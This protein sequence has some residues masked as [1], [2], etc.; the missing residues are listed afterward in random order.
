MWKKENRSLKGKMPLRDKCCQTDHHHHGCC[1]PVHTL[2]PGDPPLL[3]QPLQTSKSGIQQIIECFR[4]GTKQLKHILLKDVDTIFECKLCRSLFRGLPNLITHKKFYCTP[5]LLLDDNSPDVNDKQGQAISDLLEAM[6][7]RVDKQDYIIRLEPIETNKNAVFQYVSKA[8]SSAE[9]TEVNVTHAQ[10][11]VDI[12]ETATEPPNT[13]PAPSD[14]ETLDVFPLP[15]LTP[16]ANKAILI[17]GNSVPPSKPVLKC[18]NNSDSGHQLICSLCK[19]EFHSRRSIRRHIRKVHKKKMEELKKFIEMK[20]RPR[21]T[22]GRGRNKNILVTL[23]KSCTVCFKSF[24]TKANVRRHFDEVHRGLR[25]D[26]ITP[27]IATR[28]G[29]PLSLEKSS[30]KKSFKIRKQKSSSKTEYNLTTCKCLLCKRK[31]SSQLMLK[32][33]MLIVH[34]ITLSTKNAEKETKINNV[35]NTEAKVK[36]DSIESAELV[37]SLIISP[38]NDAKVTNSLNERKNEEGTEKKN[39]PS[40]ERKNI[41][42]T[43]KKNVPSFEKK[44]TTLVVK[45]PFTLA[46]GKSAPS[47][48]RKK[49]SAVERKNESFSKRKRAPSTEEKN[50]LPAK[51]KRAASAKRKG[52]KRRSAP[53]VEKRNVLPAKRKSESSAERKCAPPAKRKVAP[54]EKKS[55]L[56]AKRKSVL[57]AK[58]KSA[59]SAERKN[60]LPAERKNASS[61]EKISAPSGERKNASSAGRKNAS[62]AEKI[63]APSAE[64]KNVS[65]AGRENASSAEKVSAPS[66]ERKNASSAGREN[67]SSAEKINPPSAERENSSS[68]GRENASSAEKISPPSAERENSSSAGRKNSLSAGRKNSLSVGRRNASSAERKNAPSAGRKNAQSAEKKRTVSA[69][70][71]NA[72]S[73]VRKSMASAKEKNTPSV[74]R[75]NVS[76]ARKKCTASAERKRT[77]SAKK[78]ST[79]SAEKKSAASAEKKSAASTEKKSVASAEKKRAASAKKKCAASAKKK[80]A[81]SAKKKCAASSKKKCAASAK[82]KCAASAKKKCAASSRKKGTVSAE[83]KSA[84]CVEKKRAT[85]T[86]R[87]NVKQNSENVKRSGQNLVACPK[88]PRKPRLTPGFDFKK[89]YCKLCKRQFS[90]KQNLAKHIELHT[91]G[92]NIYVK[93][94]RCPLCTYETRRKRDVIRHITVVH[95]KSPNY[96]GKVTASLEVRAVKKSVDYVLNKVVKRGPHRGESKQNG[97]KQDITS[98]SPSKKYEGSDVGIEV[99]VTKNFSLHTCDICGKAFAKKTFLECHKKTHKINASHLIE[100]DNKTK[101]R[102]T[103]SKVLI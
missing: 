48:E 92:N 98:N 50:V 41:L 7:P 57:S 79:A 93:F 10:G 94:Y 61:A 58:R 43:E 23:G 2:E 101:G 95:K 69:E 40:V 102:S 31:Y 78:K 46:D 42:P 51:K 30:A 52:E 49:S 3:Q 53:T 25:R 55:S 45:K 71:K 72:S 63:S 32:R 86:K 87:N 33:H 47:T 77:A 76:S 21:Q 99:K 67:A 54:S 89:L 64:R 85:P 5:S 16:S 26:S 74:E 70:S 9:N 39:T 44:S 96:L 84:A 11:S 59:P 6:Y 65:S 103:R 68:A 22:F 36:T 75:K 81:A 24:A 28:P 18:K 88:K 38:H 37:P 8:D 4:S 80:C 12:S 83:K 14:S 20:K 19:K 73:A 97:L 100:E 35:R 56:S 13:I 91:D 90:S 29:Q 27:D 66:A 62:S 1:E 82:K 17:S 60:V 34:K 15:P